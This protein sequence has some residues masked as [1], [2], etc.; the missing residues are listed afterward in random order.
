MIQCGAATTMITNELGTV[1][2]GATV[3]GTAKSVRDELEANALY[4]ACN[5]TAMLLVSCDFGGLEPRWTLAA[6]KAMAAASGVPERN[7][8]IGSTHTGGPSIIPSNYQKAIDERYLTELIGRLAHLATHTVERATEA[9]LRH[10]QGQARIGYN[11]RC[12]WADGTHSMFGNP[13]REDFIGLEGPDDPTHTAIGLDTPDGRTLAVLQANTGHPCTFYGADFYSADFPGTARGFLRQALGEIPVLFF[14]GAQ[15]DICTHDIA[16]TERRESPERQLARLG[17][18][19]AGETLRLL[20]E[21]PP[22]TEP[23]LRHA[24][25]DLKVNLRLPSEEKLAWAQSVLAR[26]DAGEKV[27]GMEMAMAHGTVLLWKRF[28]EDPTDL[29]AIHAIRLGNLAILSQPCELFCQYG[30]DMRR[31]SPA[32]MTAIFGLT[33]GYHGYCPTPSA[34]CGGGYSGDPIYWT[35][36]GFDTGDRI[37]DQA[38]RLLHSLWR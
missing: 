35:R 13:H 37:V 26:V 30:L 12:C 19:L 6:R 4:L 25:T 14:N 9:V 33:D 20:H 21:A 34:L 36:F 2:Q 16:R 32:P 15:G 31:R 24:F 28:G 18:L 8:L 27:P 23:V 1:I 38:S 3:G 11:R 22:L 17:H 7:I 29:L 10:G 5:D